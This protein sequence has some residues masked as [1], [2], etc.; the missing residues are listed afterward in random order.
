VPQDDFFPC[1]IA[2]SYPHVKSLLPIELD[3]FAWGFFF[4]LATCLHI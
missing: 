1:L 3:F 2:Q 4:E